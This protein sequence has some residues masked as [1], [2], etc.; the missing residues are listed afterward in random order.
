MLEAKYDHKKVEENKYDYWKE[1][2][3]FNSGD[4][5]KKPFTIVI[6]PPNVTGKL[7]LGHAWDTSIQDVIIRYKRMC[8]YGPC[9]NRNTSKS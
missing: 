4:L 6:P 9:R 1:K 7:H 2:G 3:Y 5:S 8:G